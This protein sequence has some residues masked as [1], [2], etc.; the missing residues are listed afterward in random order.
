MYQKLAV[1]SKHQIVGED[2][3]PP[4]CNKFI[5]SNPQAGQDPPQRVNISEIDDEFETPDCRGGLL[6]S[7]IFKIKTSGG[8]KTRPYELIYQK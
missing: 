8:H 7:R 6:S 5:E 2:Y 1:N 3:C 4:A